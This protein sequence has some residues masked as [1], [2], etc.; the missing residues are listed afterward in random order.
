M[1]DFQFYPTP[2]PLILRAWNLFQNRDFARVLEPSA[3]DGRLVKVFK[4]EEDHPYGNRRHMKVDCCEIDLSKHAELREN[5]L[6]V[7][8]IDFLQFDSGSIY[9]HIIMNPPFADGVKHVL[10]AWDILWDGEIVAI[11]NAE[12]LRNPFSWERKHLASLIDEHGSVEYLVDQ[13]STPESERK[14]DV[15]IALVHLVKK[16]AYETGFMDSIMDS[17]HQDATRFDGIDVQKQEVMLPNSFI[18]NSVDI[19]NAA[20]L[21]MKESVKNEARARHYARLIGDTMAIRSGNGESK[22]QDDSNDW[23]R[24]QIGER[25]DELKDRAWASILRSSNVLSRLSSVAQKRVESEF[26]DIKK[27]SFTVSNVYGFLIGIIQAQGDIQI[28]MVMGCFDEITKYHTDNTVF[29]KGWV[30]NDRHLTAARRIKTTRF[31]LP[32]HGTKSWNTGLDW[33]SCRLLADFDKVFALLDGKREDKVF[34]LN[35]AFSS[36]FEALRNG[37]R[38]SCAY[39]DVRYYPGIGTIHFFPRDKKL[40]DRLNLMVGRQRQWLPQDGETVSKAFW[41]AYEQAEKMDKEI[42]AEVN[43]RHS[44]S[45]W[46]NPLNR[47]DSKSDDERTDAVDSI[48]SAINTIL[49]K[50]GIRPESLFESDIPALAAA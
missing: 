50:H 37:K 9:S 35:D 16:G 38:V 3:G 36:Q 28:D 31:I 27:L 14:T 23:V 17:L 48:N 33:D 8:G 2:S 44:G 49:E 25:Y 5:G 29:Y 18:E 39:F 46:N 41:L 11:L 15:E 43:K 24:S 6:N 42:R 19:F 32:H 7:V 20:V 34:G 21:A 12:T 30:S 10:K 47:F 4:D 13:F 40:I 1:F 45:S 26:E 22:H